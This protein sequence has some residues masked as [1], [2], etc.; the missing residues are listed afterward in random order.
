MFQ[1]TL[2]D[3]TNVV[4]AS[5]SQIHEFTVNA[6]RKAKADMFNDRPIPFFISMTLTSDYDF[7]L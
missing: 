7:S 3:R 1:S 6:L 5:E 4:I 2:E